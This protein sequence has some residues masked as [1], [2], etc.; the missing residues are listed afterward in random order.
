[1]LLRKIQITYI[2]FCLAALIVLYSALFLEKEMLIYLKP[3]VPISLITIYYTHSSRKSLWYGISMV[4]ITVT[5]VMVYI[6]FIGFF[7]HIAITVTVFYVISSYLLKDYI[8]ISDLRINKLT[9]IPVLISMVLISYLVFSIT[10]LVWDKIEDSVV[11][12]VLMLLSVL[13]LVGIC[14]FIFM[15]DRFQNTINIF[16]AGCCCLIV[17]ALL[18]V[19]ELSFYSRVFTVIINFTEIIGFYYFLKFLL[20]VRLYETS[21]KDKPYF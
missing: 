12:F 1:M 18:G 21:S 6:D 9:S 10:S 19:N 16:I 2:F 14:F 15:A 8:E 3:L 7:D 5:D 17:D 4:F 11:F 13:F 20:D